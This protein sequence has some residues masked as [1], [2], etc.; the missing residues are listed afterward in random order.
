MTFLTCNNKLNMNIECPHCGSEN[1]IVFAKNI[2]CDSCK[3]SFEDFSFVKKK[4]I[5]VGVPLLAFAAIGGFR[6]KTL[7]SEDRYPLKYEYA[8]ID[9]CVNSSRSTIS[10]HEL[11]KKRDL[12]LCGLSETQKT[13]SYS[14]FNNEQEGF[15]KSFKKN[16]DACKTS[17]TGNR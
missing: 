12:C 13:Y 3:K 15:L 14:E 5:T 17:R 10:N 11:M 4:M 1:C 8:I 16:V 7:L 9:S 6:A 2:E